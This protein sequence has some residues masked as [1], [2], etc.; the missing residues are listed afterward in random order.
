MAIKLISIII[1]NK[2][3]ISKY[4]NNK[5]IFFLLLVRSHGPVIQIP[6]SLFISK[7]QL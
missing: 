2:K 4:L 3:D 1:Y 7:A 6:F 5:E